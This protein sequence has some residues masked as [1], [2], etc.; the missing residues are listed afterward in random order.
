MILFGRKL[1]FFHI[2]V[3]AFSTAK[4][5]NVKHFFFFF[6]FRS[7]YF[8]YVSAIHYLSPIELIWL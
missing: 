3:R 2:P 4:I 7:T 5:I 1:S 8:Y 6:F